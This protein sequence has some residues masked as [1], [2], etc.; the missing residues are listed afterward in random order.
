[1]LPFILA[2]FFWG[3][4]VRNA[5]GAQYSQKKKTKRKVTISKVKNLQSKKLTQ[6]QDVD[7]HPPPTEDLDFEKKNL[8]VSILIKRGSIST[9]GRVLI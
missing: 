4:G 8:P 2:I 9:K 1:M 7:Q 3:K 5:Q 6:S